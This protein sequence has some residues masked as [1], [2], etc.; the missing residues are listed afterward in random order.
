MWSLKMSVIR[1]SAVSKTDGKPPHSSESGW[2]RH[3]A[4]LKQAS[5][6][7][8]VA[9]LHEW[10]LHAREGQMSPWTGDKAEK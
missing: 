5:F 3:S 2:E 4:S 1:S 7:G 10:G 6:G 8:T 9:A